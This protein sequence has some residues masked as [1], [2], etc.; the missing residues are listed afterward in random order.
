MADPFG[1]ATQLAGNAVRFGWYSGVNWLFARQARRLGN[2]PR[3][4]PTRPVPSDGE[5][6]ADLRALFVRDAAAVR[7]GLYPPAEPVGTITQH[8]RQLRA[9]FADLPETIRRREADDVQSFFDQV[10]PI[11]VDV[12]HFERSAMSAVVTGNFPWDDVGTWSALTR[13]RSQDE[14][15]NVLV[16]DVEQRDA[17]DCV[18]WAEDGPVVLD[19]VHDLVVVR[20]NGVTLVTTRERATHLK[21]LLAHLPDRLS[22]IE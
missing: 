7:D 5:L 16:G 18:A 8:M 13:V 9:M 19:G 11:A 17:S 22:T 3:Y 10:T 15:G 21:D 20:A 14:H 2:R 12:S 1:M 4:A 6:M